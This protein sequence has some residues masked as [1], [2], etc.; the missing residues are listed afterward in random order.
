MLPQTLS[1]HVIHMQTSSAVLLTT[2]RYIRNAIST[3][4]PIHNSNLCPF[5][6]AYSCILLKMSL[7]NPKNKNGLLKKVWFSATE[8]NG[9]QVMILTNSVPPLLRIYMY[10]RSKSLINIQS[11]I[12]SISHNQS[13]YINLRSRSMQN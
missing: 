8:Q 4:L 1:E 9:H 3:T 7:L 10:Q 5:G 13:I 11:F 12:S 6:T 2:I